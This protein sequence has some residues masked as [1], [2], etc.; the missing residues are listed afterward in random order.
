MVV[1][2]SIKDNIEDITKAFTAGAD[3][4]VMKPPVPEFLVRKI[5]LYL[6]AG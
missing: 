6:N 1:I 2:L 3:D 4:Y 5:K